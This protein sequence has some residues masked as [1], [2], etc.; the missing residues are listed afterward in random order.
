MTKRKINSIT[1]NRLIHEA[2]I[3][4]TGTPDLF[5]V[6]GHL[7]EGIISA[8][9]LF[10]SEFDY[11]NNKTSNRAIALRVLAS[12]ISALNRSVVSAEKSA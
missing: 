12:I 2:E 11:S 5:E 10:I 9:N 7:P 3:N 6:L 1:A 4:S 8:I